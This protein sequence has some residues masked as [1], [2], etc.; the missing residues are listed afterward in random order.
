[1]CLKFCLGEYAH[2]KILSDKVFSGYAPTTTYN[3][4]GQ[5]TKR[6]KQ[7]KLERLRAFLHACTTTSAKGSVRTARTEGGGTRKIRK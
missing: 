1:M 6:N 5:P 7:K 3:N 4:D 2:D